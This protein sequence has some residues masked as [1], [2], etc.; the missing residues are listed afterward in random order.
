MDI[1]ELKRKHAERLSGHFPTPQWAE[2]MDKAFPAIVAKLEADKR[3]LDAAAELIALAH[4]CIPS[5][6]RIPRAEV[7]WFCDSRPQFEMWLKRTGYPAGIN[8]HFPALAALDK[9]QQ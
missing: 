4:T 6:E 8:F 2:A 9:E 1:E 3:A 7:E 5:V